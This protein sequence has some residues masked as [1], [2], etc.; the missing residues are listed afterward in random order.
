MIAP[1]IAKI[2]ASATI[3]RRSSDRRMPRQRSVPISLLRCTIETETV[4]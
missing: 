4:L 3:S 2:N 1:A